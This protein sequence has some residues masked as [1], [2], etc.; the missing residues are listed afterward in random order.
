MA[1]YSVCVCVWDL[2]TDCSHCGGWQRSDALILDGLL[3]AC[4]HWAVQQTAQSSDLLSNVVAQP[5]FLVTFSLGWG[6]FDASV[7]PR[8]ASVWNWAP[9]KLLSRTTQKVCSAFSASLGSSGYQR[10]Q[11][12]LV[13]P[14]VQD[15][16]CDFCPAN[17]QH[18]FWRSGKGLPPCS[19]SHPVEGPS[20]LWVWME[21]C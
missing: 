18:V 21:P 19:Q 7:P 17:C 4:F 1:I 20:G 13:G 14:Q 6:W 16:P 9:W 11:Y 3:W 2:T 15:K 5:F 10:G 8:G 12:L